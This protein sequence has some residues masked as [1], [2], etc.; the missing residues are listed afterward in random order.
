MKINTYTGTRIFLGIRFH[1]F[2]PPP[3]HFSPHRLAALPSPLLSMAL[4]GF[5]LGL[6]EAGRGLGDRR[7]ACFPLFLMVW[8]WVWVWRM[9]GT[10]SIVR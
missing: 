7:F 4:F 1:R 6:A 5:C 10:G 3:P 9:W 8:V 2:A